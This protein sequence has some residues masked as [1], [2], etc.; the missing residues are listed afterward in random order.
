MSPPRQFVRGPFA[1]PPGQHQR[2]QHR[3]QREAQRQ[4]QH[5]RDVVERLFH[6]HEGGAPDEGHQRDGQ[7]RGQVP[8]LPGHRQAAC[9]ASAA[10]SDSTSSARRRPS[11]RFSFENHSALVCAPPPCPPAPMLS[12]GN[13]HRQRNIGVGRGAIELR[14]DAQM[15]IHRPNIGQNR[16]VF[17]QPSARPGAGLADARR[18]AA[19]PRRGRSRPPR[20]SP[21]SSTARPPARPGPRPTPPAGP[22]SRAPTPESRSQSPRL[23]S[24]RSSNCTAARAAPRPAGRRR[25]R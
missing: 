19:P 6:N 22:P 3:G 13:P 17:C 7:V 1:Q 5:R 2:H 12:A 9:A 15:L 21:Q 24:R 16:S 20:S 18:H 25:T 14:A 8:S 10:S 23:Q 11:S 4:K